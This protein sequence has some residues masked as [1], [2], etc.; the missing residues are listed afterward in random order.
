MKQIWEKAV[1]SFT[2]VCAVA[3]LVAVTGCDDPEDHHYD[4]TPPAGK[5]ALM[6]DNNTSS[7]IKVYI[8]GVLQGTADDDE[9]TPFDL[10]PGEHRLVLDEDDGDREYAADI[11]ILEGRLT[12]AR[13][14][15]D[16]TDAGDFDVS[17]KLDD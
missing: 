12:V 1:R 6:V 10:A 2:W 15:I 3:T 8:D 14:T 4:Y 5:G 11:D 13:V 16:P 17:I 7:D 9:E